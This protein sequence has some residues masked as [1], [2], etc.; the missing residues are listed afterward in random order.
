MIASGVA[1]D[2]PPVYT[3]AEVLVRWKEGAAKPSGDAF[4]AL[5]ALRGRYGVVAETRLVPQNYGPGFAKIAAAPALFRWWRLQLSS[6]EDPQI[7]ARDF[8]SLELVEY[9]QPNFLRRETTWPSDSLYA[10]QWNLEAI[11]WAWNTVESAAGIVVAIIDSGV[12]F[13]HPD[14][15]SQIWNNAAEVGGVAGVDILGEDVGGVADECVAVWGTGC[16]GNGWVC[17]EGG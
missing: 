9:A 13:E 15:V 2:N 17:G 6:A 12:D 1:A 8:A 5:E 14:I 10:R 4:S 11:G 16:V 7:I 3:P